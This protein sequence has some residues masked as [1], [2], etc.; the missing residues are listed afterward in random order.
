MLAR[1]RRRRTQLY[2]P[3][4]PPP[5]RRF[6]KNLLNECDERLVLVVLAR[7]F[8]AITCGK[9]KRH[10]PVVRKPQYGE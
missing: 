7:A 1:Q 9:P 3:M 8:G 4:F 2:E 6:A 5:E 10:A